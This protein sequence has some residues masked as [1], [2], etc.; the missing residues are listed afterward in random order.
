MVHGSRLAIAWNIS[1]LPLIGHFWLSLHKYNLFTEPRYI[2]IDNFRRAMD[3]ELFWRV[4]ANT[5][6][7]A[8]MVVPSIVIISFL[9]AS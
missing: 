3:D 5:L 4:L 7:Y 6:L 2:G 8:M 9:L 1:G